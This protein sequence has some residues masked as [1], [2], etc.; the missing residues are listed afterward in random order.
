MIEKKDLN[1]IKETVEEFFNKTTINV[2][3]IEVFLLEQDNNKDSEEEKR[4]VVEVGVILDEPQILIGQGGQTLFEIQRLL[5]NILNKKLGNI[6]YVNLDIND[7]KKK[8]VEYLKS[9]AKELADQV[10]LTKET[11]AL[12]PMSSYERRII[13]AELANR[14]D[15]I[16]SSQGEGINRHIVI[17]SK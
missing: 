9:V 12:I 16:T 17:S 1:K 8:K 10:S 4:E 7:Y 5:R 13:H 6:F 11:K 14:G 15:I 2:S 3:K